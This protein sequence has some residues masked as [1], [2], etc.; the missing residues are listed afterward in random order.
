MKMVFKLVENVDKQNIGD[1]TNM[2]EAQI[3]RIAKLKPGKAFLFYRPE[4]VITPNYRLD[5]NISITLSDEGI[6]SL[7]T[8]WNDKTDKLRPYPECQCVASC[9][10]TCDYARRVPAREIA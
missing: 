10:T 4:E 2:T 6:G 9:A 3:Q 7:S 8:Y 5:N 1:S